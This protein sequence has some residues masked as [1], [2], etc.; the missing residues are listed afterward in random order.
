MHTTVSRA[1][2]YHLQIRKNILALTESVDLTQ[3]NR[4]PAGLNNNLIWNAGHVI[5]TEEL[6]VFALGGHRTPSGK[7]FINRYRKGTRP[8]EDATA[9]DY[10]YIRAELLEG[11]Q[12]LRSACA[13]FD[14]TGYQAYQTSFGVELTNL[15]DA[16][17]FNNLHEAMHFGTMLAIRRLV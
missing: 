1:L 2:A 3:L 14:W 15:E 12:R 5:A 8:E 16:L 17:T 6:L 4:V 7:E 9:A 13:E 11:H 10:A